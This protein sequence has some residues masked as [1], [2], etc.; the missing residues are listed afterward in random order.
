MSMGL[1]YGKYLYLN[2]EVVVADCELVFTRT[3]RD[4]VIHTAPEL[5]H[6]GRDWSSYVNL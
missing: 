6:G 5:M 2:F 1:Y 4:T 3:A